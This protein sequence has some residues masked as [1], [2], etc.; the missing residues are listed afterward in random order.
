M[1]VRDGLFDWKEAASNAGRRAA[2]AATG[3]VQ[4]PP[5]NGPI[6]DTEIHT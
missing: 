1:A 3:R 5:K 4:I 2:A 6:N